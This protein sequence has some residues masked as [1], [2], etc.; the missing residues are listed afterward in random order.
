MPNTLPDPT[1]PIGRCDEAPAGQRPGYGRWMRWGGVPMIAAM[2]F[3]TGLAGVW[4]LQVLPDAHAESRG[5]D[6]V[7]PQPD[8]AATAPG[9]AGRRDAPAHGL[10]ILM[11]QASQYQPA[12]VREPAQAR[13]QSV[14][15]LARALAVVL[16]GPERDQALTYLES[17]D[18]VD[19]PLL[20]EPVRAAILGMAAD[21]RD[22]IR[23]TRA[24]RGDHFVPQVR[25]ILAAADKFEPY[26]V[27]YLPAV[28]AVRE[29]LAEPHPQGGELRCRQVLERWLAKHA[30]AGMRQAQRPAPALA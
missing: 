21:L 22:E 7:S 1:A 17:N 19:A 9:Q 30:K 3:A 15:D 16:Q 28:R 24:L 10:A 26:G 14:P 18:P 4:R 13:L 8:S 27:D 29:A 25:R 5:L 20:A 23:R 11:S 6:A 2:L 12:Q